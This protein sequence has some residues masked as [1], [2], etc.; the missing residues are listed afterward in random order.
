MKNIIIIIFSGIFL[1]GCV[2]NTSLKNDQ[3]VEDKK[4]TFE[5]LVENGNDVFYLA[6]LSQSFLFDATICE[7]YILTNNIPLEEACIN[8]LS[9][10]KD[11]FIHGVLEDKRPLQQVSY[12]NSQKDSV[13]YNMYSV[14]LEDGRRYKS[15]N[16][17]ENLPFEKNTTIESKYSLNKALKTM[18]K[19]GL[20]D[21]YQF[22]NIGII[23]TK[24][25]VQ[26]LFQDSALLNL[27]FLGEYINP[28]D[29]RKALELLPSVQLT[30]VDKEEPGFLIPDVTTENR[31]DNFITLDFTTTNLRGEEEV[32]TTM[33]VFRGEDIDV[34]KIPNKISF[35]ES[36]YVFNITENNFK[37]TESSY[38][39]TFSEEENQLIEK[40]VKNKMRVKFD[41]KKNNVII[42]I[43]NSDHN[44]EK[45]FN[46]MELIAL[47]N[48]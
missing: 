36:G 16:L 4:Q 25:N 27:N 13:Q 32:K 40:I 37:T 39:L 8:P 35:L 43:K 42:K 1:S 10:G 2:Q 26:F 47:M 12:L 45:M 15:L 46:G 9:F 24:S 5:E 6:D 23:A 22:T 21:E 17:I 41:Y 3:K 38:I 29:Y 18:K 7:D 44:L 31:E 20:I 33:I 30:F 19:N 14:I 34:N 11:A 28:E 48:L